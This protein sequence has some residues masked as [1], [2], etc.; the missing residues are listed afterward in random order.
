[1]ADVVLPAFATLFV[2]I[3]PLGLVPVFVA[4]T[5]DYDVAERRRIALRAILIA[6][7]VLL[8]FALFGDAL[9]GLLGIGLPAFRIA[10]GLMLLL[11]ALEM[12]FERRTSRRSRSAQRARAAGAWEEIT[13]FPL[14]VPLLAGPGAITS[15][16]LLMSRH[17]GDLAMQAVILAVLFVVLVLCLLIFWLAAPIDRLL[18]PVVTNV[19][20]RLLGIILAALAVQYVVDGVSEVWLAGRP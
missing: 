1:M 2:V 14:A 7:L 20:T 19:I 18:G 16:L 13:V 8:A 3:D 10:G 17:Q 4:L 15:I 5:A 6:G 11:I 12:V 9:L